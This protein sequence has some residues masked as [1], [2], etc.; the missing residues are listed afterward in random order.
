MAKQHSNG[1]VIDAWLWEVVS[2]Q[3]AP[4]YLVGDTV[5]VTNGARVGEREIV[6]ARGT[7]EGVMGDYPDFR[8]VITGVPMVQT[9][10]TLRLVLRG[11]GR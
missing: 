5:E 4:R 9:A 7:V 8:Y 1:T 2:G 11:G 6:L 3:P 10:R